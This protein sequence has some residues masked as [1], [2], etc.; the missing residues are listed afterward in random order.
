LRELGPPDL[1]QLTKQA[2]RNPV[3]QVRRQAL[4]LLQVRKL[5]D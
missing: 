5:T 1:V 2:P 3:K 4:K